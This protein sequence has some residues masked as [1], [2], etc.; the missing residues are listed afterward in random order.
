MGGLGLIGGLVGMGQ[1]AAEERARLE[2]QKKVAWD[3]YQLGKAYSDKQYALQRTEARTNLGIQQQRLGQSVDQS[4]AE[5]NTGLLGQAYGV[6]NAQIQTASSVGSS[7]AAEGMSGTRGASGNSLMR[8]YE[9]TSLDRNV[10]LQNRQNDLALTSLT[11]QAT[12]SLNDISR[13][14]DSWEAGGSRY[15]QKAAQDKY[16]LKMAKLEESNF[17]W[18]LAQ[19][20]PNGMDYLSAGMSGLSSGMGFGQQVGDFYTDWFGGPGGGS[21]SPAFK[22]LYRPKT[23]FVNGQKYV[24]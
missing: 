23:T 4:M 15:Q 8:A 6:Q 16:N 12:N 1:Q 19:A 5:M 7:L 24:Q 11:T 22:D 9:E 14:R 21:S 20:Q 17:D 10:A 13:E 3:Q 2:Q 18:E